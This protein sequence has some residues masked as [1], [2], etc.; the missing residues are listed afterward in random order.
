MRDYRLDLWK[1]QVTGVTA[2]H[3][4][5]SFIAH[6]DYVLESRAR[7]TYRAL[8]EFLSRCRSERGMWIATPG[9]VNTWW[10]LRSRMTLTGRR[11]SWRIEGSGSERAQVAY[12][13]IRGGQITYVRD[14]VPPNLG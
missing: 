2:R 10:R 9:E 5:L 6:P 12:A 11:G 4:L 3:G 14:G 8:L 7:D 1:T 13:K